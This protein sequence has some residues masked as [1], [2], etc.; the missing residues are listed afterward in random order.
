MCGPG[1]TVFRCPEGRRRTGQRLDLSRGL[2]R[3]F[4]LESRTIAIGTNDLKGG[5]L[6]TKRD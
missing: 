2:E 5:G 3:V 6:W 4:M 1:K